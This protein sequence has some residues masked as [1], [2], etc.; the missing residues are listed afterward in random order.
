MHTSEKNCY[1]LPA[2]T[3]LDLIKELTVGQRSTDTLEQLAHFLH[4]TL[5]PKLGPFFI[6]IYF[7]DRFLKYY[8]PRE[9]NGHSGKTNK[10]VPPRIAADAP[11]LEKMRTSHFAVGILLLHATSGIP[12]G[13][14]KRRPSPR[15]HS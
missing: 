6:E 7:P 4:S 2:H 8:L 5:F 3:I 15:S 11:L 1:S 12:Q 14:R 10:N 13:H 9:S